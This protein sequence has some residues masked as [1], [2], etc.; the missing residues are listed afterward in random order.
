MDDVPGL[1]APREF[2]S[3]LLVCLGEKSV[4]HSHGE[5]PLIYNLVYHALLTGF[6]CDSL[7]LSGVGGTFL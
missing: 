1:L 6:W 7:Q 4:L 2:S 5:S 3:L